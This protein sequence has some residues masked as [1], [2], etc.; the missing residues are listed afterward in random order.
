MR[1]KNSLPIPNEIPEVIAYEGLVRASDFAV[2]TVSRGLHNYGLTPTQFEVMKML[3]ILGPQ[4]QRELAGLLFKTGGNISLVIDNLER[5]DLVV[6]IRQEK[7]RRQVYV[8]LTVKG[9]RLF[10]ET[11]L[12]HLQT[13]HGIMSPLSEDE[14]SKFSSYLY[15]LEANQPA[16]APAINL[17]S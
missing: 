9:E 1:M 4:S 13:I 16:A 6:R 11:Y 12:P 3:R 15:R 8:Q 14:C 7:D 17:V 10:N 5:S 2:L